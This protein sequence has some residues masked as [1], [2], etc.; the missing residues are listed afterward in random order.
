VTGAV[1]ESLL[2]SGAPPP[3]ALLKPL[4]EAQRAALRAHL[5]AQPKWSQ[6]V[7]VSA[8]LRVSW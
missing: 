1:P 5:A 8:V 4:S 7:D 3:P 2:D 6:N